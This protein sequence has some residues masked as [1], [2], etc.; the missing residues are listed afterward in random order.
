MLYT[1][2][3]AID[4]RLRELG[5]PT[6]VIDAIDMIGDLERHQY[7]PIQQPSTYPLGCN[8]PIIVFDLVKVNERNR[9]MPVL[10][11]GGIRCKIRQFSFGLAI[12][13]THDKRETT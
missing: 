4:I 12:T 1:K 10:H 7:E 5:N 2:P 11:N 6:D 8:V 3:D 9:H 13:P